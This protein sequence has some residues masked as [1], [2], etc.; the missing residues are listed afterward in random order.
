MTAVENQGKPVATRCNMVC[1]VEAIYAIENFGDP[2]RI[3]T[4]DT[5]IRNPSVYLIGVFWEIL[6]TLFGVDN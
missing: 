4:C 5:R 1:V 3:R 2:G 6:I